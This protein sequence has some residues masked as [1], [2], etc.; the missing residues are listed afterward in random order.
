MSGIALIGILSGMIFGALA[1][2]VRSYA[3]TIILAPVVA[4]PLVYLTVWRDALIGHCFFASA[5]SSDACTPLRLLTMRTLEHA[6]DTVIVAIAHMAVAFVLMAVLTLVRAA[7][8]NADMKSPREREL[9]RL[10]YER[11]LAAQLE[12]KRRIEEEMEEIT[13]AIQTSHAA[14]SAVTG[15]QL[16]PSPS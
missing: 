8:A 2:L 6:G 15:N 9:Q 10:A 1:T 12:A 7:I 14:R 3:T 16:A 4:A 5:F 11:H 13:R